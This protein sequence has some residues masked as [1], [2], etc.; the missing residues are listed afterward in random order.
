MSQLEVDKIVPQSGTTLTIGD[1]GDTITVASGATLTGDLN[2]SNL[3]SGTVP[4]ARITGAYTGITG[5]TINTDATGITVRDASEAEDRLEV[6]VTG[7]SSAFL[8]TSISSGSLELEAGNIFL[9]NTSGTNL[10][11]AYG[12]SSTGDIAFY[13]D[14][15]TTPKFYWDASTERLGIGTTSSVGKF[16]IQSSD[17]N[18]IYLNGTSGDAYGLWVT[19]TGTNFNLGTWSGRET[20]KIDGDG[21]TIQFETDSSERMRIDSSGNVLINTTD[22]STIT[23]GI[24]LRASDNAIAAVV[25][26]NP[27]G[28][29]GRLT[30]DGDVIKIRKDTTTVGVIGTQNWGIGT[31]SPGRKVTIYDSSSPYLALQNSTSGTTNSD[32]M[33]IGIGGSN[34]FIINYENQ[35]LTF[36]TN[37]TERMRIDSSGNVGIGTTSPDTK[38]HVTGRVEANGS[39]YRAIFGAAVQDADMT[40]ATGGNGSE[41]QIQSPSS[42]R[43][44]SL[45]LGGAYSNNQLLGVIGFYNSGNTDG[46]RLRAFISA[47]QEGATA[48]EQGARILF[49]TANNAGSAPIERMR[50]DSSGNVGIGTIS[51]TQ[52]LDVNGTVKATAF[53]G[54]GSAL[55][56]I[57]S[58]AGT[59]EAFVNFNGTGSVSIRRSGNVSSITD[60][61]TG[62]YTVN[63]T[64]GLSSN[65]AWSVGANVAVGSY[66][67]YPVLQTNSSGVPTSMSSTAFRLYTNESSNGVAK[68]VHYVCLTFIG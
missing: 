32:G 3:T 17:Q 43:P 63:F 25:T 58:G 42:G 41:V 15:G 66:T 60:H 22:A 68:D 56:G 10:F 20:I 16:H 35:P 4:D 49:A 36:S 50:I 57:S 33:L 13:E 51:P 19:P 23:A 9:K 29:F 21:N 44:A 6:G 5:L 28:Y 30:S 37:A 38:L 31:G 47:G 45:T 11:R 65:Y 46:K 1:S 48:N 8:K 67:G 34:A 62:N 64:S 27:S 61:G 53:Q 2:A 18:H 40:G 59:I 52:K 12:S 39:L 7:S 24:K 26:S 14:T 54:D 55:T